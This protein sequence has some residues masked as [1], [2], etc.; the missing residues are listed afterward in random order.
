MKIRS[1]IILGTT[2]LLIL[3][4]F[5]LNNLSAMQANQ[6][7][8]LENHWVY[9]DDSEDVY[10]FYL[11]YKDTDGDKGNVLLYI[12]DQAPVS[13]GTASIDPIEGQYYEVHIPGAGLDDYT[14]FYFEAEDSNGAVTVLKDEGDEPFQIGD[15]DGWGDYPILSDPAVYFNGDDWVFNVTYSDSDGDEA[16]LVELYID[17]EYSV[18]METTDL[19][20]STGQNY[21]VLVLENAVNESTEFYFDAEDVRGSYTYLDDAEEQDF[22]KVEDFLIEDPVNGNNGGG[23]GDTDEGEGNESTGWAL[24]EGWND[25]EVIIGIVALIAMGTGSAIGIWHRKKKRGRF[26]ELLTQV[27]DV[28]SSYKTNPRKCE[29]ELEK[30][31]S[32]ANEDLKSGA[33]EESNYT[34]IKERAEELKREIRSETLHTKM[35]DIPQ[36]M[37]LKIKDML[38]DGKIS[39][40]EYKKFM[41][42]LTSADMTSSDKKEMKKLVD[43]WMKDDVGK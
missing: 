30:I 31:K 15:F 42:I 11:D 28:Y 21:E 13:M 35:G 25:P 10:V 3:T 5:G 38:I 32:V 40:K 20:P 7:P 12:E 8:I 6:A 43:S 27:D 1:L 23:N 34:L 19:D 9:Y 26:T 33:I 2:L 29:R 41:K 22:F 36:E 24:P 18:N 14:E 39:R 37:E 16:Y 4:I 17:D